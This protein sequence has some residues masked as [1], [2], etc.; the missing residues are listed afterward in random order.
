MSGTNV[1]FALPSVRCR[2]RAHSDTTL[3]SGKKKGTYIAGKGW[4]FASTHT[5]NEHN[6]VSSIHH[7]VYHVLMR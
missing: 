6:R 7:V 3:T 1:V 2:E 4:T 5:C